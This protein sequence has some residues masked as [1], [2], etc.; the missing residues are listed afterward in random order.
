MVSDS[1][2]PKYNTCMGPLIIYGL[3]V[4]ACVR[5]RVCVRE[6]EGERIINSLHVHLRG[7]I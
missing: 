6:R 2:I 7:G 1:A 3:C 5:A 4:R